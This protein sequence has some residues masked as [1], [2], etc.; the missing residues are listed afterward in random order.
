VRLYVTTTTLTLSINAALL[1][2]FITC[3]L[4]HWQK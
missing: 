3:L 2:M 4:I 1:E